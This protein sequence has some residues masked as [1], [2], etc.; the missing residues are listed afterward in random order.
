MEKKRVYAK[1]EYIISGDSQEQIYNEINKKTPNSMVPSVPKPI[2]K[3][4][5]VST[6]Q[7]K[8]G[9]F[10]EKYNWAKTPKMKTLK[11]NKAK[12]AKLGKVRKARGGY[13]RRK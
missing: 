6:I 5:A 2:S 3:E 7:A 1:G 10:K 11:A 13:T 8:S 12:P 9:G 4:K